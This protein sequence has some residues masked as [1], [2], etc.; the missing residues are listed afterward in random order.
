MW[1]EKEEEEEEE[2][3]EEEVD[4]GFRTGFE[5]LQISE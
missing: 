4:I 5:I 3:G 2:K 1:E